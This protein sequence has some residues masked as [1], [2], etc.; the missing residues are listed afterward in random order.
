VF[1]IMAFSSAKSDI[2]GDTSLADAENAMI[3][4]GGRRFAGPY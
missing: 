3:T 1:V 2:E 4:D